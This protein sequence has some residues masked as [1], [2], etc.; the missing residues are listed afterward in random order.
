MRWG[1]R[2]L[3]M[4]VVKYNLTKDGHVPSYII[5]GGYF[6]K[7]NNKSSPQDWDLIGISSGSKA[8]SEFKTKSD[9]KSYFDTYTQNWKQNDKDDTKWS[10]TDNTE[11]L[12]SKAH[13]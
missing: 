3:E 6:P 5:D 11:I 7:A 9:L 4:I 2:N 12:W 13:G 1:V 10:Q 8:L